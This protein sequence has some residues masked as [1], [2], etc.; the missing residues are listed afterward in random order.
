MVKLLPLAVLLTG[1]AW[2]P[3]V[4]T[5]PSGMV[6]I[7]TDQRTLDGICSHTA[8]DGHRVRRM[9]GEH[10]VGCYDAAHDTIYLLNNCEGAEAL[11]HELAHR[12]GIS[13]PE[14]AGFNW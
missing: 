5:Y 10:A 9:D 2:T 6:I 3:R 4:V 12:E 13:D 8:D 11:P 1:C 7:R 14:K